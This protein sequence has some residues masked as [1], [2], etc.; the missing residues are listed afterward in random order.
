MGVTYGPI[1]LAVIRGPA[2]VIWIQR[3]RAPSVGRWAL[4]G[5]RIEAGEDPIE[6]ARRETLEEVGLAVQGGT[7]LALVEERFVDEANGFLYDIPVHVALF[8]DPGGPIM[9]LDGVAD[10]AR[11]SEA[12]RG[13]LAPDRRMAALPV[14]GAPHGI[15]ARI[16]VEGDDLRI[17]AWEEAR[18]RLG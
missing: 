6:A 1:A 12:P 8:D 7:R 16:R 2:G 10:V 4:P 11:L 13:A 18:G 14:S 5:G 17:L 9:P 15:T 3:D